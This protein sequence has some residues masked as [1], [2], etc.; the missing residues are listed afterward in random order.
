MMVLMIYISIII[1]ILQLI[2]LRVLLK[3]LKDIFL[4]L[5]KNHKKKNELIKECKIFLNKI[6]FLK[7]S[8]ECHP[9]KK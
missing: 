7:Y 9:S 8:T 3:D 6:L 5:S 2:I 4:I 1:T